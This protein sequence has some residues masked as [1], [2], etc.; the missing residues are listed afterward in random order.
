M[1]QPLCILLMRY[2]PVMLGF[3][4]LMQAN[5]TPAA[6]AKE[7][8]AALTVEISGIEDGKPVPE[9]FAFCVEDGKDTTHNGDNISPAISWSGAPG[10]TKSFA[11]VVID[12]D[13]P[14]D[15]ALA[16]KAGK[17]IPAD[18]P[19]RDYYHWMMI[20][21]PARTN[22]IS[23]NATPPGKVGQN[24]FAAESRGTN[25]YDGPCPP[26][27]DER[28]HHYHFMVH[29]LDVSSLGLKENFTGKQAEDSM[30]GH[31]LATGEVIGIYTTN[32]KMH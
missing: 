5:L 17:T 22:S 21:I 20:D 6:R 25:G 23:E 2:K 31:I 9:K 18:A 27:N 29:A 1:A 7:A 14:S 19:R 26:W 8:T 32:P 13:V 15:F 16:N 11:I 10:G 24:D 28:L 4:L 30:K 3:L 12:K